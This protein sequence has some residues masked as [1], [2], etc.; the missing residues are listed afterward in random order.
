MAKDRFIN[1][2]KL[3]ALDI[4]YR[5]QRTILMEFGFGVFFLG[6]LGLAFL[7]FAHQRTSLTTAIGVYLL[8]LGI[9]YVPLLAYTVSISRRKSAKQEVAFELA[10][11]DVYRKKYGIQQM[12]IL[13]PLSIPLLT[14]AQETRR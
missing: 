2:R 9:N 12:L 6:V 8:L 11:A 3:A 10:H 5:G 13:L 1:I 14:V 7:L 4:V